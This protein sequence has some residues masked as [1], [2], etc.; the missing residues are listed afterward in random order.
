MVGTRFK[1]HSKRVNSIKRK[2]IHGGDRIDIE[3][4]YYVGKKGTY[5]C[6]LCGSSMI[7]YK[8][9]S[10]GNII[11]TCMNPFCLKHKDNAN[12]INVQL[13]KLLKQQQSISNRF[14]MDYNGNYH[15]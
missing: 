2:R 15:T 14:Y 1:N 6:D 13:G 3:D 4:P 8:Q 12:S 7:P 5:S 9:D 11:V 10:V